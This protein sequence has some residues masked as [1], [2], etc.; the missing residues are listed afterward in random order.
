MQRKIFTMIFISILVS[1]QYG[2]VISYLGCRINNIISQKTTCDCEKQVKDGANGDAQ[3]Y[4]EKN[5][6]KEKSDDLF[7]DHNTTASVWIDD[8]R[9]TKT[10]FFQPGL[11]KEH[12]NHIFQP[13]RS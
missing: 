3:P 2:R 6:V 12:S 9:I 8:I 1:Y 13:P 11:L 10:I 4:S 5:V 7:L